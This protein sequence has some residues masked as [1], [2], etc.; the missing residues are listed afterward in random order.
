MSENSDLRQKL[1]EAKAR[2]PLQR[3]MRELGYQERHIGNSAYCPFHSDEHKSF[4]V[5][6]STNGNGWQWKCHAGCG[7][8]DEIDFLAKH[9][10]ISRREAIKRYLDKAGF[11]AGVPSTSREYPESPQS[12]KSPKSPVF[13]M[14][15]MSNGQALERALKA[16]AARNACKERRTEKK[17][18]WQMARDFKAIQKRAGRKLTNRE[19]ML[20]FDEWHRVS[21]PFLDPRMAPEDY[22]AAFLAKSAK[23]RI[24]TGE[25]DTLNK[26]LETVSKLPASE[27]PVIPGIPNA[28]ER[29]RR[30]AALHRE[31]SR[32]CGGKTYF[33]TCR[34]T[35]KAVPGLKHQAAWNVNLALA[36][37]GVVRVVRAGDPRPGGKASQYRYL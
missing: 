11:P 14:Y 37:L 23:V 1:D 26:A 8:G 20:M 24:P 6:Q 28:P 10:N 12:R 7:H 2:L 33:V 17:A 29:L 9:F 34:D 19:A 3:L 16:S 25:G 21:E 4:S 22:L 30:I 13:P 15:P 32:L 36:Q 27:L 35:A 31:L 5:F 18:L